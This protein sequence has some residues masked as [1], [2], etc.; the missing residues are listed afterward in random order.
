MIEVCVPVQHSE[1]W[2]GL[3]LA[4]SDTGIAGEPPPRKGRR[5]PKQGICPQEVGFRGCSTNISLPPVSS[6][7]LGATQKMAARVPLGR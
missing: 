2:W 6:V 5:I 1:A 7:S 3:Q 4:P